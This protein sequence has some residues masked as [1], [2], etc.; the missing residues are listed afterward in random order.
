MSWQEAVVAS[1]GTISV[2]AIAAVIVWSVMRVGRASVEAGDER[3]YKRLAE[4]ATATQQRIAAALA[5]TAAGL[6]EVRDRMGR[7]EKLMREVE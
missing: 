2:F 3:A 5:E 7:I 4:E 1:V 6:G